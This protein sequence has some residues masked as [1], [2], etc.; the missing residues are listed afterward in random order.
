VLKLAWLIFHK[1]SW[2]SILQLSRRSNYLDFHPG[3]WQYLQSCHGPKVEVLSKSGVSSILYSRKNSTK[4][5]IKCRLTKYY[6]HLDTIFPLFQAT[7]HLK[8]VNLVWPMT[9]ITICTKNACAG[10]FFIRHLL[11]IK[12]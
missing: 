11:G 7:E 12:Q 1:L 10:H 8:Q 9:P 6:I 4:E 2:S 3:E 5:V